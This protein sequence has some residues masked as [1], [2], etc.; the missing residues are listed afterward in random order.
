M[1][2]PIPNST[3]NLRKI[4]GQRW[5]VNAH[6][7]INASDTH[8]PAIRGDS[9]AALVSV[10]TITNILQV[11]RMAAA[12]QKHFSLI[13]SHGPRCEYTG[14]ALEN[15]DDNGDEDGAVS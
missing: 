15:A 4:L 11:V 9:C 1:Q 10:I 8:A 6:K 2:R 3:K 13:V 14:K 5:R 7:H 12:L